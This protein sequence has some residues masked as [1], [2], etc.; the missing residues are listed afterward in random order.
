[1]AV[2][3]IVSGQ[4]LAVFGWIALNSIVIPFVIVAGALLFWINL[5]RPAGA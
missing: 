5:R 1:M 3:S 4:M 2:A